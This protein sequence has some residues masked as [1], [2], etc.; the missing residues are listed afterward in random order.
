VTLESFLNYVSF[1]FLLN[2][3]VLLC[4]GIC[5]Q[6]CGVSGPACECTEGAGTAT[7]RCARVCARSIEGAGPAGPMRMGGTM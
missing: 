7:C 5:G 3:A 1:S 4:V 2:T 6:A